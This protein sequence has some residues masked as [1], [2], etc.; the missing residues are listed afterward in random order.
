MCSIHS[1][2]KMKNHPV[3]TDGWSDNQ[4]HKRI[5]FSFKRKEP[6]TCYLWVGPEDVALSDTDQV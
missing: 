5:F 4:P 6:H 3:S 1:R 2:P